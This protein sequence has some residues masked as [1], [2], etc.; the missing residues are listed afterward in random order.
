MDAL[1]D[2][3]HF[4]AYI[5]EYRT[6]V[7]HTLHGL[8][9]STEPR[10]LYEPV[11]YALAGEGKRFRPI[12]LF[13]SSAIFGVPAEQA[14]PAAVA[15]EVFH[16]FTLVHD[17]IMD[18][19]SSRR[20]RPT[21]HVTWD[22]STAILCGDFLMAKSYELLARSR[23]EKLDV[24]LARFHDMVSKLCEGQALDKAFEE[25][26]HVSVREYIHMIDRK[27]GALL[28]VS[29][30]LGG[31]LGN[32]TTEQIEKLREV[33]LQA[34]RAFQ[35]QDDLL[36]LVAESERWGKTI[37]GDLI[38]GKKTFLL[39][40]A[41]ERA[42]G[43]DLRWFSRITFNRGLPVEEVSEARVRMER[44]GVIEEARNAVRNHTAAAVEVLD[45]LPQVEATFALRWLF[46]SMGRRLH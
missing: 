31:L 22:E 9:P 10:E 34:G 6:L 40:R 26:D 23:T 33:G 35:I 2:D 21:V 19:A 43:E 39:L 7:D 1:V 17:D 13:L 15:I 42:T 20:G 32:A 29:L 36:D 24:V 25:R 27:T 41:L 4:E 8:V 46:E 45:Q 38:E 16:T 37:G 12:L 18:H 28:Q 44:L 11:R 14:L 5:R 30:E 3:K